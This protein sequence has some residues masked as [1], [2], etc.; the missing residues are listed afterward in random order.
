MDINVGDEVRV[1]L[2]DGK[3]S[4]A[5]YVVESDKV[6]NK[7]LITLNDR[8]GKPLRVIKRRIVP[9]S[10]DNRAIV[11]ESGSKFKAVCPACRNVFEVVPTNTQIRCAE[12]G[13]FKL[14]WLGDKPMSETP[15][16]DLDLVAEKKEKQMQK[17]LYELKA[18]LQQQTN[19]DTQNLLVLSLELAVC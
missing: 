8:H 7:G 6:D 11:I 13:I 19:W 16:S 12:H 2:W 5:C 3:I 15:T 9:E 10:L 4:E 14:H 18:E 17:E 1:I